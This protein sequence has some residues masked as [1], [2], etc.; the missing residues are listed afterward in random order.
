MSRS[1]G[2]MC[3]ILTCQG[4]IKARATPS[5]KGFKLVTRENH[6][7]DDNF[8]FDALLGVRDLVKIDKRFVTYLNI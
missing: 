6:L 1:A 2:V 3:P 4:S 8:D 5:L 7:E